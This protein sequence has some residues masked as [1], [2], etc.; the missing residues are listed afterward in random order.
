MYFIALNLAYN[1]SLFFCFLKVLYRLCNP[2][3]SV[4]PWRNRNNSRFVI[5]KIDYY[6]SSVTAMIKDL[7]WD[8]LA[9]RRKRVRLCIM[10]KITHNITHVI[11][12]KYLRPTRETRTRGTH[13]FKYCIEFPSN[14][15]YKFSYF[16]RTI[17]EWN[18]LPSEIVS[19]EPL[20]SFKN[21]PRINLRD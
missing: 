9:S 14:G 16:R 13:E 5:W 20:N 4:T 1:Y 15:I 21:H 2:Y 6:T 11:K 19:A 3:L 10:Y 12:D 17:R 18:S 7:E 8:S